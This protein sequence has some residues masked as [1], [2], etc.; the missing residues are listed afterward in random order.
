MKILQNP[1][2]ASVIGLTLYVLVTVLVWKTPAPVVEGELAQN[3]IVAK[4]KAAVPSWEFQSQEAEML[5]NELKAEKAALAQREKELNELAERLKAERLEINVV[6]QAVHQ[7]QAQVEANIVR[8]KAE[9]AANLK[10][11]SRTYAAMS[12]EGAAPIMRELEETTLLKILALMKETESAP[13]LEEM[14]RLSADEAKRV[15]QLTDRLR[16]YIPQPKDPKKS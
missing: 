10:K 13:L 11:L 3:V 5:V 12:P 6:T 16:F 1:I 14:A 9:E 2:V 4:A 8:I 15:A 7:L